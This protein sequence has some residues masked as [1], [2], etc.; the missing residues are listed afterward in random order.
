MVYTMAE[1]VGYRI[2]NE[3]DGQDKDGTWRGIY[4]KSASQW[5]ERVQEKS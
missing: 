2:K 3:S 5:E 4:L 1:A